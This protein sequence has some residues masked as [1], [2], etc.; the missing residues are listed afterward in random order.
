MLCSTLLLI[1]NKNILHWQTERAPHRGSKLGAWFEIHSPILPLLLLFLLEYPDTTKGREKR[2]KAERREVT[3]SM[4]SEASMS[5]AVHRKADSPIWIT[6]LMCWQSF[7]T[8]PVP[9]ARERSALLSLSTYQHLRGALPFQASLI[10]F[11]FIA[12]ITKRLL[13][14]EQIN[15]LPHLLLLP[16]A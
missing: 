2:R 3:C 6:G 9:T 12:V 7:H 8:Y 5:C 1:S 16:P 15:M 13:E 14:T 11:V 10:G 4:M